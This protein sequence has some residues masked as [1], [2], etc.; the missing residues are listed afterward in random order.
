VIK[1]NIKAVIE[2]MEMLRDGLPGALRRAAAADRWKPV[3]RASA[4]RKLRG[5][6][7]SSKRNFGPTA[8]LTGLAA[9]ILKTFESA[10]TEKGSV[11][12]LAAAMPDAR[13][14]ELE[15]TSTPYFQTVV[16]TAR[17]MMHSLVTRQYGDIERT[18]RMPLA[19]NSDER[20]RM[21]YARQAVL[22]WVKTVKTIE[23]TPGGR[24]YDSKTGGPMKAEEIADRLNFILGLEQRFS[25]EQ[26][27]EMRKAAANLAKPLEAFLE[28]QERADMPASLQEATKG[29]EFRGQARS[30]A[31]QWMAAIAADW[32]AIVLARMPG[33]I[34][35]ELVKL[36]RQIAAGGGGQGKLKV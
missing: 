6:A 4:E 8:D 25:G 28:K 7:A 14:T 5:L 1:S 22:E 30:L 33:V 24:D 16:E 21:N 12:S 13:A 20:A 18:R 19:P 26:T 3:L 17:D 32:K 34:E 27:V 36:G 15:P 11:H 23:G 2:R 31:E 10:D 9:A 29:L 35:G